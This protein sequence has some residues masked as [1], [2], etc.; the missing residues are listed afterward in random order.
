MWRWRVK[1]YSGQQ[2]DQYTIER[3]IGKG[4]YGICFLVKSAKDD[5]VVIKKL[6]SSIF[7]RNSQK[8]L[9]EAIIL[10]KLKNQRIPEL[11]GII[12]KKGF[13][14]Y[15]LE[16]K[17]GNTFKDLLF[18]YNHQFTREEFFNIGV[19]LIEI[20]RYLH[21]KGVVHRDIRI[22]NV[23][24]N[25]GEVYLIDF[26]LAR[27]ADQNL[28]PYDLDYSYLA[29]F[30][31][32]LLYSSYPKKAKHQKLPWYE[33]LSLTYDQ[34]MFLKKL[35]GLE[36]VYKNICDIESDFINVFKP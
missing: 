4:R 5:V 27:W 26:G 21:D 31:L 11:L 3:P 13:Y 6:R 25:K 29:D 33:E 35:F 19:Q 1:K 2:I 30:F 9:N 7:K 15:V 23:L 18:K 22:P 36:P 12:N 14:G 17:P 16:F 20:I 28:N 24:L 32:Y 8:Y 34:K 10:S